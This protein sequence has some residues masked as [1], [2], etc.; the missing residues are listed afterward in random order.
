MLICLL[1]TCLPLSGQS[2]TD[3]YRE[4]L[5]DC[6]PGDDLRMITELYTEIDAWTT[7]V[8]RVENPYFT[9]A[10]RYCTDQLDERFFRVAAG[11]RLDS[12][13][14]SGMQSNLWKRRMLPGTKDD[15]DVDMIPP[16]GTVSARDPATA[17]RVTFDPRSSFINCSKVYTLHPALARIY[18]RYDV[19]HVAGSNVKLCALIDYL[20][21]ADYELNSVK[22]FIALDIVLQRMLLVNGYGDLLEEG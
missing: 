2:S 16:G 11:S 12:L 10:L 8:F 21:A 5:A 4:G 6:L 20:T 19:Y 9:L 13:I 7:E 22:Y 18:Q 17:E 14:R 3:V 15:A 1:F